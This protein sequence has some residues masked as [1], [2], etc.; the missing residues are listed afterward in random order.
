M[1][2]NTSKNRIL[3]IL[4]AAFAV[5]VIAL[6]AFLVA[7]AGDKPEPEPVEEPSELE[8]TLFFA[9][10]YQKD[11][12]GDPKD[13]LTGIIEAVK[14]DKSNLDGAVF[15]GDYSNISG[16]S[17]Y[18]ATPEYAISEIKEVM[19]G[20]YPDLSED[21]MIFTQGNHDALTISINAPGIHEFDDYIVYVNNA[22]IDFPWQQGKTSNSHY[23]VTHTAEVMKLRFEKMIEQGETDRSSWRS[24]YRSISRRARPRSKEQ[25]TISILPSCSTWSMKQPKS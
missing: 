4:T 15:C 25:G 23:K 10:D 5:A 18:Q 7:G 19:K 11:D 24:T 1:A 22:E 13:N 9:S 12:Q 3:A 17:S 6:G 8:A 16:L 14:E 21:N 20:A 2:K